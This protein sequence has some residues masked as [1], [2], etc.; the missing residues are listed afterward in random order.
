MTHPEKVH[1]N[2]VLSA[3]G[4]ITASVLGEDGA[5]CVRAGLIWG[6]HGLD[7]TEDLVSGNSLKCV[8]VLEG[9]SLLVQIPVMRCLPFF[10]TLA[11]ACN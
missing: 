8:K 1:E 6:E 9:T 11:C 2:R 10:I 7:K 5:V 3:N 4:V